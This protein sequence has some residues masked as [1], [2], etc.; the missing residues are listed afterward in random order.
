M[1]FAKIALAAAVGLG[2]IVAVYG[3][4][5]YKFPPSGAE[6]QASTSPPANAASTP[7]E[8]PRASYD[9]CVSGGFATALT[10]ERRIP[11]CAKAIISRTLPPHELAF[12]RLTNQ[13]II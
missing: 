1:S 7:D 6:P 11:A 10:A 12:A 2:V 8:S 3:Y 9:I 13:S 4:A 5:F